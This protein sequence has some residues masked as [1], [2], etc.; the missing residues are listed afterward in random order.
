MHIPY[1]FDETIEKTKSI[2]KR[3]ETPFFL[4]KIEMEMCL[5]IGVALR[6][7]S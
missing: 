5:M 1:K 2:K 3:G 4:E 7:T 6:S